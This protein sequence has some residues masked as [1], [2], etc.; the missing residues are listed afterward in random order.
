MEP[1]EQRIVDAALRLAQRHGYRKVTM[2][3]IAAEA[4]MSRPSLYASFANKEAILGALM[5]DHT[6]RNAAEADLQLARLGT[7]EERLA[8]L[9]DIWILK[10]YASVIGSENGADLVANAA[11][12]A[13][14]ATAALYTRFEEQLRE[15]LAP[16]MP[17]QRHL[18][19][20]DVAHIL[21]MATQGLKA[22]SA[23]LDELE[24]LISGLIAMAV[25]TAESDAAPDRA[26]APVA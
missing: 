6:R 13:P 24:R 17:R 23:T 10:P 5:A 7:L 12:Y 19:A 18:S 9:F 2:M 25:A 8:A 4:G 1:K 20:A 22:T 26:R 3:D 21:R 16:A 11:V 15:I 14:R